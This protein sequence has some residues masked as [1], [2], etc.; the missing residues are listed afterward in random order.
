M[1]YVVSNALDAFSRDS[2]NVVGPYNIPS[3]SPKTWPVFPYSIFAHE[4]GSG[5]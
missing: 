2:S 5:S 4:N 3:G 1:C